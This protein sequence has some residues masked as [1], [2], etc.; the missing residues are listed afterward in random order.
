[1]RLLH[2]R[3]FQLLQNHLRER[4]LARVLAARLRGF[5]LRGVD[6]LVVFVNAQHAVR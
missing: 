1:V 2:A 5:W 3:D 4:L 6:Q